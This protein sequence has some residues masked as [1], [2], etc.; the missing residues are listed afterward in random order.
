METAT[1][2]KSDTAEGEGSARSSSKRRKLGG[3]A[4]TRTESGKLK[5][6]GKA[7]QGRDAAGEGVKGKQKSGSG[8]VKGSGREDGND[9]D[10]VCVV[11]EPPPPPLP[12]AVFLL[13]LH[14]C[15][16]LS[17]IREFILHEA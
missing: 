16:P 4:D 13:I 8:D 10:L 12:W 6:G 1:G 15:R 2:D 11:R 7:A 9:D 5:L 17:S 3:A 14:Y